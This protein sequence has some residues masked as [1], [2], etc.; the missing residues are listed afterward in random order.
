[1]ITQ[2]YISQF[3]LPAERDRGRQ[4]LPPV[5]R[6][7]AWLGRGD[8]LSR[9]RR[10]QI[11]SCRD[12][13]VEKGC[14]TFTKTEQPGCNNSNSLR[15]V[16]MLLNWKHHWHFST[17]QLDKQ[18]LTDVAVPLELSTSCTCTG[19]GVHRFLVKNKGCLIIAVLNL[20][21]QKD[22]GSAHM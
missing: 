19:S 4:D 18:S 2:S 6:S 9:R 20:N 15:C 7:W 22:T 12:N 14:K 8:W 10:G 16:D 11:T 3:F 17:S 1:M 21:K 5:I 13:T